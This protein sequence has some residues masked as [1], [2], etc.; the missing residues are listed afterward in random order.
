MQVKGEFQ[1]LGAKS[2]KGDVEGKSYDSTTLF[3]VM[4]VSER[5]GNAV[6]QNGVQ[7][8]FGKSDE[9][10][11]LK[12]LPFPVRAELALKLTTEGYEVEGFRPL[13]SKQAQAPV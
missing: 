9:F 13:S 10:D 5:R 7:L 2:F 1:I 11:K 4:D 6:G 12:H 3:V 8:K